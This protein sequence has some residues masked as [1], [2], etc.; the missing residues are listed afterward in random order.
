MFAIQ[1]SGI[2]SA[3]QLSSPHPIRRALPARLV[4]QTSTNPRV[5]GALILSLDH[6]ATS[7]RRT[8]AATLA[9]S[10]EYSRQ[11]MLHLGYEI[12][13]EDESGD[14]IPEF[15]FQN[16]GE[17]G[18]TVACYIPSESGKVSSPM[19]P[20]YICPASKVRCATRSPRHSRTSSD[21]RFASPSPS[22]RAFRPQSRNSTARAPMRKVL[23]RLAQMRIPT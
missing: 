19:P 2:A 4:A 14:R 10:S 7:P 20:L 18:R 11:T 5:Y 8:H 23:H 3:K 13:I 21:S 15:G 12:W 16:E 6:Q 1:S 9:S 22:T 17:D